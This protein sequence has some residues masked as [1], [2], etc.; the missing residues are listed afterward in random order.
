MIKH[1]GAQDSDQNVAAE[2]IPISDVKPVGQEEDLKKMKS[3][4]LGQNSQLQ[5]FPITGLPGIGKTTLANS[6]YKD[7]AMEKEFALRAWVTVSQD[8]QVGE[9]F[10]KILTSME[11]SGQK[12]SDKRDE[13]K[14]DDGKNLKDIVYQALYG[15]KYLVVVDDIWDKNAWDKIRIAFP[16][17]NNGSRIVLTT[18][19]KD[20]AEYAQFGETPNSIH[21]MRPLI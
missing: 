2:R 9:V 1:S 5:V 20:V 13:G 11:T 4:I 18:R 7:P 8:Y 19:S 10:S 12:A 15:N 17:K 3:H 21:T 6:L 16:D 14:E